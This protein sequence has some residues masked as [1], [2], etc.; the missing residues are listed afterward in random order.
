M[1]DM[2]NTLP[3]TCTRLRVFIGERH[4]FEGKPA[5]EAIVLSARAHHLAGATVMRGLMGY[6]RACQLHTSNILE[7]SD[8]LPMVVEIVDAPEKIQAFLAVL[9]TMTGGFGL[10]TLE[11]VRIHRASATNT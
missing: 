9:E 7:L 2:V 10:V 5:F 8:D 4:R 6:G 11:D 3:Q 1:S